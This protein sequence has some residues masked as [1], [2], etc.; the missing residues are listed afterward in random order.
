MS[1]ETGVAVGL[2]DDALTFEQLG[3]RSG[4]S[5]HELRELIECGALGP[6]DQATTAWTFS[7]R[8][9]VVARMASRLR[10]EFALDDTHSVAVVLRLTQ[11]IEILE[12]Q[13]RTSRNRR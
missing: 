3:E 12:M 11:R 8:A 10:E 6:R 1:N 13:L 2:D 9:V 5:E 4:F 7:T